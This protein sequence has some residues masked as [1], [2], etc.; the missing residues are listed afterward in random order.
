MVI[1]YHED[2]DDFDLEWVR[3]EDEVEVCGINIQRAD[4]GD[5]ILIE[6]FNRDTKSRYCWMYMPTDIAVEFFDK[7]KRKIG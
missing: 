3:I 5:R 2:G 1:S 4:E 7:L 6:V